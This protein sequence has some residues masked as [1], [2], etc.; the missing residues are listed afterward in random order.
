[1]PV[2]A[3]PPV[4]SVPV[5]QVVVTAARLPPPKGE[6][7]FA[8]VR[9]DAAA[10]ATAVRV[11]EALG[12]TP[13]VSLFRRTSSLSANPTTQGISLRAIAPS[14]AGRTLVLLDGAP[15]NDP[16]GGWV[17]W[18]QL[19]PESL[20]GI[21]IVRGAGAGPYGAGAL[22][23]VIA[24]RERD[25]GAVVDVSAGDYGSTRASAAGAR[26]VGRVRLLASLAYDHSDGYTPVRGRARGA[27]D[28]P[29]D[30]DAKS[31]ALRLDAPVGQAELSVRL[32][33]FSEDR[34]AGLQGARAR[35]TGSSASATLARKPQ[36]SGL[37]WRLQAWRRESDL[38]NSSAA[39]AANRAATT[40]ANSQDQTP[41][42]GKGVNAALRWTSP[43][44]EGEAGLD[45]RQADGQVQERFRYL[46]GAFTRDRRAGGETSVAG[47]YVE[48]AWTVD[49]WLLT[50]G[51]RL[52]RWS[53][54]NGLRLERD[55]ATGTVT[56]NERPA[57]RDGQ[58]ATG[59]FG[60]RRDL[61]GGAALRLAAY[62]GFRPPTLNE[63]HR[64]FRVGNDIT[65]ANADLKPERL[66]G[67]ETGASRQ[68]PGGLIEATIFWNR[69]ED[70]IANVTVG[71][72]P[73]TFPRAG[74]V[75]AGGVLRQRRNTGAINAVGL[76]ARAARKLGA[77]DLRAA[78]SATDARLDGGGAAPQLT[79][80][81]PAQA[82]IWSATAG[83][84]WTVS[85]RLRLDAGL[86]WEGKRFEDD[87]NSRTLAAGLKIDFRADWRLSRA[88]AIYV[89]ADNLLD[90]KV[91]VS[92]TADGV[93][94]YANPRLARIG[95][96]LTFD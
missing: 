72:G 60:A 85:D 18:S 26:A 14:G 81:R 87:L 76:E 7:A 4:F 96:R 24:L 20:A 32:G 31:A 48:G 49:P 43:S 47:V 84:A 74:F 64:P 33:G 34:G 23:G 1:M 44:L 61:G 15:L 22:T 6:A 55:T 3:P 54:R 8:V 27:A 95:L 35:A 70:P 75:P 69:I 71:V 13:G 57:D 40:P 67:L 21:D 88:A 50:G 11:D 77:V 94:G 46:T 25:S 12:E 63:L 62:S 65:E 86:T 89:A 79:G 45:V 41:A 39:V 28:R 30:L 91:E 58:V 59:R 90:Q 29:L 9:L 36:G 92:R 42:V 93:A 19:A 66:F 51:L 83:A 78:V 80:K 37:G 68:G 2:D 73:G 38:Y 53:A 10:L 16:F 52:D 56:L 5:S 17:I 82:P